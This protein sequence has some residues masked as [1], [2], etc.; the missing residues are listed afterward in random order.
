MTDSYLNL[1]HNTLENTD[2][3]PQGRNSEENSL[4]APFTKDELRMALAS[5]KSDSVPGLDQ[6]DYKIILAMP[7][8]YLTTY[9]IHIMLF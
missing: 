1:G 5:T 8:T 4:D 9:W 2:F 7:D 3:G 6:I